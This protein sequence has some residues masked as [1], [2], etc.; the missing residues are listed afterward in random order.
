MSYL[1]ILGLEFQKSIV[2]FEISILKFVTSEFL[3][4]TINFGIESAFSKSTGSTFS[5]GLGNPLFLKVQTW[6]RVLVQVC[7]V[8]GDSW[9]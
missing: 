3:T 5:K 9:H 7:F 1:G 8:K 6:I 4:D 2:I